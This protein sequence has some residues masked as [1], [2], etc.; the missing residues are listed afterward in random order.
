MTRI[1][2][3]I[4]P[5]CAGIN[6]EYYFSYVDNT[7]WGSGTKLPHN[8]TS[9]LGVMDGAASDLCTGL[10]W[11]GVEIHEPVRLLFVIETTPDAMLRILG[12]NAGIA[13]LC[14]NGWVHLS[15]VHPETHEVFVFEKGEFKASTS[16]RLLS[17]APRPA[18]RSIG[19]VAGRDHSAIRGNRSLNR[20]VFKEAASKGHERLSATLRVPGSDRGSRSPGADGFCLASRPCWTGRSPSRLRPGR[21]RASI[22]SGLFARPS[23]HARGDADPKESSHYDRPG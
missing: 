23:P 17:P 3:A 9:L 2:L 10:P 5:V 21:S 19:I 20:L 15:V 1:L 7:G 14:R 12:K 22:I 11:Q 13:R 18:P 8:V 16:P 6:L 4:F